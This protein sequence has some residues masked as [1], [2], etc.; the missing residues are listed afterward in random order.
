VLEPDLGDRRAVQGVVDDE[1]G[2]HRTDSEHFGRGGAGG[3][4]HQVEPRAGLL[5][6]GVESAEILDQL[7]GELDA[8][9]R[10][11][12][13]GGHPSQ[14][15]QGFRDRDLLG[16]ASGD[17][18]TEHRVEPM[19]DPVPLAGQVTMPLRPQ[20]QDRGV[21]LDGDLPGCRGAQRSDRNGSGVM[22]IVLVARPS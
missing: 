17:E 12:T 8:S 9:R 1:R 10:H 6:L 11:R 14:H 19:G 4:D 15:S 7:V 5:D 16:H 21:V 13:L 22:R 2:D 3:L 18:L 20:L